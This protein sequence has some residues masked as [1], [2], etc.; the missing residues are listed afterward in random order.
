MCVAGPLLPRNADGGVFRTVNGTTCPPENFTTVSDFNITAYAAAP[1]YVQKQLPQPYQPPSQLFCVKAEYELKDPTNVSAGV[2]VNNYANEGAVNGP[3]RGSSRF[4]RTNASRLVAVPQTPGAGA[5][6]GK[7]LVGPEILQ[8][9]LPRG[10]RNAYGP[11]WVVAV[12]PSANRTIA[13]DWAIISG[14]P[15]KYLAPGGGCTTQGPRRRSGPLSMLGTDS[16]GLWF[17]SR[18]PIDPTAT[19]IMEQKAAELG[20]ATSG[21]LPVQQQ[22]CKYATSA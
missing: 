8:T 6:D 12:G 10:W 5:K 3:S 11:Y 17:F 7:L 20:I 19:A 18:K 14:G 1:W 21:L 9:V 16:G 15:P 22:G 13:Y 2:I 4:D